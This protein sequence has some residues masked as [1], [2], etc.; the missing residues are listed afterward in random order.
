M[1]LYTKQSLDF[2]IVKDKTKLSLSECYN[3]VHCNV[4]KRAYDYL[5]SLLGHSNWIWCSGIHV[6]NDHININTRKYRLWLLEISNDNIICI[7][8][9]MWDCMLLNSPYM[10]EIWDFIDHTKIDEDKTSSFVDDFEKL[11][12][13][14]VN[15]F[16]TYEGLIRNDP[17][18]WKEDFDDFLIESPVDSSNVLSTHIVIPETTYNIN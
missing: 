7:N 6:V 18:T 13:K 8:R 2:N 11:I 17:N 16:D 14:Y 12:R 5:F 10:N 15:D 1:I 3:D 9:A 4:F